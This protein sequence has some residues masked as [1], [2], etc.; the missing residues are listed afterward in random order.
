MGMIS[1][2]SETGGFGPQKSI[3]FKCCINTEG[4]SLIML[5]PWSLSLFIR[6]IR[7]YIYELIGHDLVGSSIQGIQLSESKPQV[8]YIFYECLHADHES[9]TNFVVK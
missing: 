2:L 3:F 4:A 5:Y 6:V 8:T 7:K 1:L 9:T